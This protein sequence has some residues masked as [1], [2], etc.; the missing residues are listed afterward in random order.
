MKKKQNGV[1]EVPED[2]ICFSLRRRISRV[3]CSVQ[4]VRIPRFPKIY[5]FLCTTPFTYLTKKTFC[6][7]GIFFFTS[8]RSP[9]IVS[10]VARV[11]LS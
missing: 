2:Y 9:S 3:I 8:F 1:E 11:H 4:P 6:C 5:A 7:A 10:S